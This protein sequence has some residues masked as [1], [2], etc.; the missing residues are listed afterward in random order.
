MYAVPVA[1]AASN[2]SRAPGIAIHKPDH[3]ASGL[4]RS[5]DL[6]VFDPVQAVA[7]AACHR[8]AHAASTDT[9]ADKVYGGYPSPTPPY[10]SCG[11]PG[12]TPLSAADLRG[13]CGVF[14][15]LYASTRWAPN[16]PVGYAGAGGLGVCAQTLQ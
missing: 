15:G 6:V 11:F 9:K 4:T 2:V 1:E 10:L 7:K 5:L 16:P 3:A 13:R 14:V 8:G 12:C